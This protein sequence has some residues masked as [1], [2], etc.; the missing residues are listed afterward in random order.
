MGRTVG[1][2][3]VGLTVTATVRLTRLFSNGRFGLIPRIAGTADAILMVEAGRM[4]VSNE[5]MVGAIEA[6]HRQSNPGSKLN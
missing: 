1:A 6:G 2:V 3:R 5:A 4:E